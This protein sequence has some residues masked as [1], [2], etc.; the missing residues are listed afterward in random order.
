MLINQFEKKFEYDTFEYK[1]NKIRTQCWVS[2]RDC[3]KPKL[4]WRLFFSLKPMFTIYPTVLLQKL[5]E[6]NH[7]TS[8]TRGKSKDAT[9]I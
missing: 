7:L 9:I 4:I 8:F 3:D 2:L 1:V 6:K 5:A